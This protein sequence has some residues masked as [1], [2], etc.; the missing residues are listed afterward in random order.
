V[1]FYLSIYQQQILHFHGPYWT[2]NLPFTILSPSR[3]ATI[4]SK[5]IAQITPKKVLMFAPLLA[6]RVWYGLPDSGGWFIRP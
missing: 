3:R 1:C 4:I 2:Y 6:K 5:K